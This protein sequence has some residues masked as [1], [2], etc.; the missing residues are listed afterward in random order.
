MIHETGIGLKWENAG[1]CHKSEFFLDKPASV[2]QSSRL[3]SPLS[4]VAGTIPAGT[5]PLPPE[6]RGVFAVLFFLFDAWIR[7]S[8][9]KEY[10]S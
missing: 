7:Y 10:H 1:K 2:K 3:V 8:G 4:L 9:L 6:F 5:I